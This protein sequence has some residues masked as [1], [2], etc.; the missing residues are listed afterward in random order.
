MFLIFLFV[1]LRE[2]R[3]F[4]VCYL[5]DLHCL[6]FEVDFDVSMVLLGRFLSDKSPPVLSVSI[7]IP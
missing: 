5:V 4:K 1:E 2:N 6:S 3:E 7:V